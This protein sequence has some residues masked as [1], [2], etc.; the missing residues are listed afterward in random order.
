MIVSEEILSAALIDYEKR[1]E[2]IQAL[3]YPQAT[4]EEQ[5][6]AFLLGSS[7]VTLNLTGNMRKSVYAAY[8]CITFLDRQISM[9]DS[10]SPSFD[11]LQFCRKQLFL[12]LNR[13]ISYLNDSPEQLFNHIFQQI[14]N[15]SENH[16]ATIEVK[17]ECLAVLQETDEAKQL[18][19]VTRFRNSSWNEYVFHFI[20]KSRQR[21]LS[22]NQAIDIPSTKKAHKFY[23]SA[24]D[25]TILDGLYLSD[26][27][28]VSDHVLIAV[29]GHFQAEHRYMTDSLTILGLTFRNV[30]IVI[31]NHRN[32]AIKAA[33][34]ATSAQQLGDDIASFARYFDA[35]GKKISLYGMCGGVPHVAHATKRLDEL[36]IRYKVILDRFVQDYSQVYQIRSTY[37][38]WRL[39]VWQSVRTSSEIFSS[40]YQL[41]TSLVKNFILNRILP[42]LNYDINFSDR[43]KK[44]PETDLLLLYPKASKHAIPLRSDA[45]EFIHPDSNLRTIDKDRRRQ[46]KNLLKQMIERCQ[47]IIAN[48]NNDSEIRPIFYHMRSCCELFLEQI[49]NEKLI[50]LFNT[51]TS[52]LHSEPLFYLQT[53]HNIPIHNFIEGFF[54]R[55]RKNDPNPLLLYMSLSID[56]IRDKIKSTYPEIDDKVIHEIAELSRTLL[57]NHEYFARSRQRVLISHPYKEDFFTVVYLLFNAIQLYPERV[58]AS[59]SSTLTNKAT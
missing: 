35:K 11:E 14:R 3:T 25:N 39:S 21:Y 7:L 23:L 58:E 52:T 26:K 51:R 13:R 1:S 17:Y 33:R 53:R 37:R 43:I 31:A 5:V 29:I 22:V 46:R 45:D 19:M 44:I 6:L 20:T 9:I 57:E 12:W 10:S 15:L 56:K 4:L 50:S 30:D 48:L 16:P 32:Y 24:D 49:H 8:Y 28:T 27:N 34:S 40:L 54:Y 36:G 2:L 55:E 47:L 18:E 38:Y 41:G 42:W 59:H